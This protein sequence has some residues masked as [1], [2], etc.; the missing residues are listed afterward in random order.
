MAGWKH[1]LSHA[2]WDELTLHPAMI[3]AGINVSFFGYLTFVLG[4]ARPHPFARLHFG[5]C[6]Q[7]VSPANSYDRHPNPHVHVNPDGGGGLVTVPVPRRESIGVTLD[8]LQ[9]DWPPGGCGLF[10]EVSILTSPRS[11]V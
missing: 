5:H 10:W 11:Y 6:Q 8:V 1:N 7:R 2:A 4:P 3:S 9:V